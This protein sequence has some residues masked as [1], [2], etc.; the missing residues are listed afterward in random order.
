[1]QNMGKEA[2]KE[3]N[4][5]EYF[6]KLKEGLG[7]VEIIDKILCTLVISTTTVK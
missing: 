7:V 5:E 4:A 3:V 1:M 6:L 2:L